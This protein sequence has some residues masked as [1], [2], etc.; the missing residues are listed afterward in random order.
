M[1]CNGNHS[2]WLVAPNN[3]SQTG[4]GI[5]GRV[6]FLQV[7]ALGIKQVNFCVPRTTGFACIGQVLLLHS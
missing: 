5:R 6:E 7:P 4:L 1:N 3:L 2:Q